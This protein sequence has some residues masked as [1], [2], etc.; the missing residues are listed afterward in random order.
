MHTEINIQTGTTA[1]KHDGFADAVKHAVE[2]ATAEYGDVTVQSVEAVN[3]NGWIDV[4]IHA[5]A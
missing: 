5:T 3:E 4:A 2:E 1:E